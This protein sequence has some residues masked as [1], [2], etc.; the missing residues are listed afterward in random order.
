MRH[1]DN[2]PRGA[3]GNVPRSWWDYPLLTVIVVLALLVLWALFWVVPDLLVSWT[4]VAGGLT[5]A[6][7]QG[8]RNDA[9][10]L[11][12]QVASGVGIIFGLVLNAKSIA[13]ARRQTEVAERGQARQ[14]ELTE[15]SQATERFTRAVEQLANDALAVRLGGIYALERIARDSADSWGHVMEVLTAYVR[16]G[17]PCMEVEAEPVPVQDEY[18]AILDV[19]GRASRPSTYKRVLN[20]RKTD[21]RRSR[22]QG[23]GWA[24]VPRGGDQV[25]WPGVDL[26]EA[27]LRGSYLEEADLSAASLKR[28]N[29]AGARLNGANLKWANLQDAQLEGAHLEHAHLESANLWGAHLEHA[30]LEGANVEGAFL[31]EAHIAPERLVVTEG[32]PAVMPNGSTPSATLP[33]S[34][35]GTAPDK[36][37]PLTTPDQERPAD[38]NSR[39]TEDQDGGSCSATRPEE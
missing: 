37:D 29:V 8:A 27:D 33:A 4:T 32:A 24:G 23:A 13:E 22:I 19:L 7:L 6:E 39:P 17:R 12:V 30:N 21:L 2:E 25:P 34:S 10:G 35:E 38:G 3:G 31:W 20:L 18:Q 28:A 14:H 26:G 36:E 16:A 15:Q 5:P 11:L 1:S 9:R